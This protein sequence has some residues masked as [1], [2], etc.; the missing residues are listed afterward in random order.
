MSREDIC[1]IL[2]IYFVPD[3]ERSTKMERNS[4]RLKYE[5]AKIDLI[6]IKCSD[7][8]TTS[9]EALDPEGNYDDKAWT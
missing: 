6:P 9:D 4:S 7:I 3:T 2:Y 8:I 1:R 5:E